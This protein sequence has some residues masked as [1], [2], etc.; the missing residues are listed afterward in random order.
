[1]KRP[2][3]HIVHKNFKDFKENSLTVLEGKIPKGLSGNLYRSH[4]ATFV[5]NGEKLKHLFEGKK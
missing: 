1:M 3:R 4:A 2:L 5:R